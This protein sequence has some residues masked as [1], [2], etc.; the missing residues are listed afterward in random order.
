MALEGQINH[1]IGFYVEFR[2]CKYLGYVYVYIYM[3]I[4][5]IYVRWEPCTPPLRFL[6]KCSI[7]ICNHHYIYMHHQSIDAEFDEDSDSKLQLELGAHPQLV[8]E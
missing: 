4:W 2:V 7:Y 8:F 5:C 1:P 3:Y 6:L